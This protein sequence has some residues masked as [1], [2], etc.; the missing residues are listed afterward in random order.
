ME[1]GFRPL[2]PSDPNSQRDIVPG[3]H[4]QET[5]A[6][7]IIEQG[8]VTADD[9]RNILPED[10]SPYHPLEVLAATVGIRAVE[11]RAR[12]CLDQPA[13]QALVPGVHPQR[14]LGLASVSPKVTLP[15][16]NAED[17]A[18]LERRELVHGGDPSGSL[19]HRQVSRETNLLR[20]LCVSPSGFP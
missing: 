8:D 9:R 20:S 11:P 2:L 14:D 13:E 10:L 3:A 5:T 6:D 4:G 18:E 1:S 19:F 16:E 15:G 12:D 17:V 7:V